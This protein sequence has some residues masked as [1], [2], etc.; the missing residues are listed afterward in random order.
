MSLAKV[1]RAAKARKTWTC[2]KCGR[3]INVG[4]PVLSYS[5]GFRG[6]EVRRCDRVSCYP[7]RAERESSMVASV[8]DAID[9]ADWA[10]PASVEDLQGVMEEIASS[11]RD[12]AGEYESS[13]MFE[14]NPDL[15]ERA[16]LLNSAADEIEGWEP[17]E[18]E[19]DKA[20]SEAW[21]EWFENA[22]DEA[23]QI[24]DGAEIP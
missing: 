12:V 11:M 7:T 24:V 22:R 16:E 23:Q 6:R 17:S 2:G 13:E 18:D 21:D 9:G 3:T 19:P 15:Q 1:H 10:S 20:D 14:K 8:Y 4:E 5:V